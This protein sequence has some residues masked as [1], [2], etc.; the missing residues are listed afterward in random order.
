LAGIRCN[1]VQFGHGTASGQDL[2]IIKIDDKFWHCHGLDTLL[3]RKRQRLAR[4]SSLREKVL[5]AWVSFLLALHELGKFGDGFQNLRP[6]L[7][8]ALQGRRT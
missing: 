8:Q 6:N 3:P 7:L 1:A 2:D 5:L 4:R